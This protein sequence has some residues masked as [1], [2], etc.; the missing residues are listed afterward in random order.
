MRT[1]ARRTGNHERP[2]SALGK[3][4]RGT[5]RSGGPAVADLGVGPS[6]ATRRRRAAGEGRFV[7]GPENMRWPAGPD[8]SCVARSAPDGAERSLWSAFLEAA[9]RA[10]DEA[11]AIVAS[12]EVWT[13]AQLR[14]AAHAVAT[15]VR[16]RGGGPGVCIGIEL[17]RGAP[18][19]AAQLGV[20]AA[21][22]C[23]VPLDPVTPEPSRRLRRER[24][25]V[26]RTLRDDDVARAIGA[27]PGDAETLPIV[28]P[29]AAALLLETSGSTG[30][31]HG[32]RIPHRA[33]VR[34]GPGNGFLDGGPGT[35]FLHAAPPSFDASIL[36]IW[37]PLTTGGTVVA[38]P[39]GPVDLR[40]IERTIAEHSV[41]HAWLTAALFHAAIDTSPGLFDPLQVVLS[42]GDVVSPGH[43]SRLLDRR[44]ELRILN[45]YGPTE[46]TTFTTVHAVEVGDAGQRTALEAGDPIPIGTPIAGTE[47]RLVD[48]QDS[49]VPVGEIGEVVVGGVGLALGYA[50]DPDRTADR[51]RPLPGE[52]APA[53]RTGD[54]GRLD[55][56]GVLHFVGR[57]DDQVKI[58][59]VRVE[60][61][62]VE[63]I[64]SGLPGV[65]AAA[66]AVG[67][68]DGGLGRTLHGFV[69]PA[70]GSAGRAV[71]GDPEALLA[72]LR[73]KHPEAMVPAT[74][75]IRCSIPVTER[76]KVD[77]RALGRLM[78]E[79]VAVAAPVPDPEVEAIEE[80]L[81]VAVALAVVLMRVWH[82]LDDT[83]EAWIGAR[84]QRVMLASEV[85]DD[86][87]GD[88]L[89]QLV[90]RQLNDLG[91]DEHAASARTVGLVD[92][93]GARATIHLGEAGDVRLRLTPGTSEDA[94]DWRVAHA[95]R[96]ATFL[97]LDVTSGPATPDAGAN[98]DGAIASHP[99]RDWAVV[100]SDELERVAAWN[101]TDWTH[102]WP[103]TLADLVD[104]GLEDAPAR[105]VLRSDLG[106]LTAR[107]LREWRDATVASLRSAGVGPGDRVG[108]VDDR[109]PDAI[110]GSLALFAIGAVCVPIDPAAPPDRRRVMLDAVDVRVV[111]AG[112]AHDP[113]AATFAA[114]DLR[115]RV[116]PVAAT[117]AAAPAEDDDDRDLT[118][119]AAHARPSP[120]DVALILFTSGSTGPPKAVPVRHESLVNRLA[121]MARRTKAGHEDVIVQ[122]NRLVWDVSWWEVLLPMVTGATCLLL[123]GTIASDPR[124]LA[125]TVR[126]EGATMMHLV[127]SIMPSFARAVQCGGRG[128]LRVVIAS[129]ESLDPSVARTHL[130]QVGGELWNFYGPTEAAIDVTAWRCSRGA[131]R[132]PIGVPV[133]NVRIR[134]VGADGRPCVIG[135][136]GQI[137]LE[138]VQ[139]SSGYLESS[140]SIRT[141]VP[142]E[143]HSRDPFEAIEDRPGEWRYR[144]G[145]LGAWCDDGA[146]RFAG[147]RDG[148]LKLHG[149]RLESGEI[150]ATMVSFDGIAEAAITKLG[151]GMEASLAAACVLEPGA[152]S[153]GEIDPELRT[154]LRARLDGP[155]VPSR[156]VA[157]EAMPRL[158]SGKIDRRRLA[159]LLSD[160]I[161]GSDDA[162]PRSEAGASVG[163]S[164]EAD[165][166]ADAETLVAEVWAQIL[167]RGPTG[168]SDDFRLAG[169]DSLSLM[170]LLFELERRLGFDVPAA[171]VFEVATWER[172]VEVVE[173]VRRRATDARIGTAS[174]LRDDIEIE[175][176]IG[177][178][179]RLSTGPTPFVVVPHVGGAVGFLS[180]FARRVDRQLAVHGIRPVG[181]FGGERTIDDVPRMIDAW[182]E[183][184][185][186]RGWSRVIVCGFSSGGIL[187][188]ELGRRLRAAGLEVPPCLIVDAAPTYVRTNTQLSYRVRR[189]V[190]RGVPLSW[191]GLNRFGAT[192]TFIVDPAPG[193]DQRRV[194]DATVAALD[195]HRPVRGPDDAI[196]V[197]RSRAPIDL[198]ARSWAR[199]L[200]G[201]LVGHVTT[202]RTHDGIWDEPH[203]GVVAD[204]ALEL[205]RRFD[206]PDRGEDSSRA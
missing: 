6:R 125:E 107:Q 191:R 77:R 173:G 194:V 167:G 126:R 60:P 159:S 88:E 93:A 76:G 33:I 95:Y 48:A 158:A 21:G 164:D 91:I 199:L 7:L 146:I 172:I 131:R 99:V 49:I 106:D 24:F 197:T 177:S 179:V 89:L 82:P 142:A 46:N 100:G 83:A 193:T 204:A 69:V 163:A 70:E 166:V 55:A 32:V 72:D 110:V 79:G 63:A 141:E 137:E 44:P 147:R 185:R 154:F 108:I 120:G 78:G 65:Q 183:L 162:G 149:F 61:A 14:S 64:L 121:W 201:R 184:V 127:P 62:A 50:D 12:G 101:R 96:I 113:R 175:R 118:A 8:R 80:R 20:M 19:I 90:R 200:G 56:D 190:V 135:A 94:I 156:F 66:V 86:A 151:D 34:L 26:V 22:A 29:G 128:R 71:A 129:G 124:R 4:G 87:T 38:I 186:R 187:A 51:F 47:L 139:V 85:V 25:G 5:Y 18:A 168:P 57:R 92:P 10:G 31:P 160:S 133:E 41:S 143:P 109:T 73:A 81:A 105:V 171:R 102:D 188:V 39:P 3:S 148:Q 189:R 40:G 170:R 111:L 130:E 132:V 15:D 28:D 98:A 52:P 136:V 202:S 11:S 122:K 157:I 104:A 153:I 144:T 145:D 68:P 59:G 134:I 198:Q 117:A 37:F 23:A 45:G 174:G 180:A 112:N 16:A 195:R 114:L 119:V 84:E 203:V 27:G 161:A 53:Y 9:D 206:E 176:R 103:L 13:Y 116:M 150:E 205:A 182:A 54:L 178:L 192:P 35:R 67:S 140:H 2:P 30:T 17:D 43:V 165:G 123:D 42:G 181:T 58:R 138:G 155:A 1:G 169:G 74:L 196:V 115:R 152:P 75:A 97:G 36:E